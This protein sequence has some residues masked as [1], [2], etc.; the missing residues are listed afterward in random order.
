MNHDADNPLTTDPAC[1]LT[2]GIAVEGVPAPS[3]P[4]ITRAGNDP[5]QDRWRRTN[6]G[7]L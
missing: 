4:Q 3:L 7:F 6:V 2:S 1:P 5:G